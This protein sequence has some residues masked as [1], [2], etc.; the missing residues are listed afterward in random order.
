M[1]NKLFMNKKITVV[2]AG[3]VG[4]SLA[5]LLSQFNEVKILEIDKDKIKD[6]NDKKSVISENELESI[7]EH[8]QLNFHATDNISEAYLNR[9]FIIIAAPTDYDSETSF[10]NTSIV[11]KIISDIFQINNNV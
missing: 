6:I 3:Y 9:D 5:I 8:K 1:I 11:E 7:L 10:F 2:G 4:F